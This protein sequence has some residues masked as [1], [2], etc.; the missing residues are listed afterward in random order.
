M[1]FTVLGILDE[2]SKYGRN[3]AIGEESLFKKLSPRNDQALYEQF[4]EAVEHVAQLDFVERRVY[5][6]EM[7]YRGLKGVEYVHPQ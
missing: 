7:Q 4:M 2:L 5:D 3:V 1:Q 6:G